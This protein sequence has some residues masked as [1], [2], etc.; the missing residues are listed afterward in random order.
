M[1]AFFR[2]GLL[3]CFFQTY[4]QVGINTT[5]PGAQLEIKASN[6][7]APANNDGIIIPKVDAFPVTN[8]TATQQ[9]M[10]VYLT[11]ASG[12]NTP[13][14][15][16]WDNAT[17]SWIGIVSTANGDKDWYKAGTTD[18]P[19]N[20]DSMYHMG[21]V[22]IGLNSPSFPLH[23]QSSL[24]DKV[25]FWGSGAN[26]YGF[27]L[28]S[29]LFQI[30][31]D[32]N[33]SDIAFGYGSSAA[34]TETVRFKGNGFVGIG[35]TNPTVPLQF[36]WGLGDRISF[37]GNAAAH[38]GIGI[39]DYLLQIHG[40]IVSDDIAFGYGSSASFTERMRIKG[41]GNVGIGTSSPSSRLHIQN[42]TSGITA[43]GSSL[44]TVEGSGANV[45]ANIL[46][47]QE[48]GVLFGASGA[49][50]NGG[51][52][53][54]STTYPNSMMF[55]TG[56]NA[57]RMI[58]GST[59]KVALGNFT[60]TVQ[61]EFDNVLGE[62]I[63]L[64]GTSSNM[65]GFGIQSALLQMY[66]PS[67]ANDIAFGYG[68]TD[69][70]VERMRI[71]GTGNVG[72]GTSAPS[73]RLHVQNG[74]SGIAANGSSLL[75]VE[76]SGTNVYTNLL[77]TQETGVLFGASGASANGGVIYNSTAYPNSMMFRTGG[78]TNRMVIGST[79]NVALGNFT[80]EFPLHFSDGYGD[81]VS[82]WGSTLTNHYGFGIQNKLLQIYAD[83]DFSDIA[84][85]Y[86]SS[87]S[88]TERMRIKGSGNIGIGTTSPSSKLHVRGN[89]SGMTPNTSALV[90]IENDVSTYMNLL[91]G[92]E[93]GVLFGSNATA[94]SGGI[95]YNSAGVPNGLLFRT[96]NNTTKMVVTSDGF[97]GV[98]GTFTPQVPLHIT[99][100]TLGEKI[101]IYG[102]AAAN[103]GFGIQGNLMQIHSDLSGSDIA[104]GYG[105]SSSFTERMRIKGTGE[106]GIGTNAPTAEL[107]VNGFTKMGGSTAPAVKMIKLTGTT[108]NTQ[109]GFVQLVHGLTSSKILSASVLV[110][111]S[112]GNSVP[113]SYTASAGYEYDYYVSSTSVVVWNKT[114]NSANILTKPIRVLVTYEE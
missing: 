70:L 61:L 57:N 38:H 48:T 39:Q 52:I 31:S 47:T 86:G 79:G 103:Y 77:S 95:I 20:T 35:N 55:R 11:T 98:G 113:P 1:K 26:H 5:T 75:T 44:L 30:H 93:T 109:G 105:S 3:F 102:S 59:G 111:Y 104:F 8:P 66:T 106:V 85:G 101:A 62:K 6:Q 15:Y 28:Q 24:G 69:A 91:S 82:L 74:S 81:K 46:S 94:T 80:P 45:Y 107:E 22:G 90:T 99:D 9:G 78:N 88:F 36:G 23:F 42:G 18:T 17:T 53:Y 14:F 96:N 27:G 10:M 25:S 19:S 54:N 84:F 32:F 76:G 110:E 83:Y 68:T 56:G 13:G 4:A 29:N 7:S 34:F 33:F 49:S 16:Y 65:Y 72:I 73:S 71:K 43:N 87:A 89:S 97:V 67:S 50:A 64:F 12:S 60:P 63:C 2:L 100:Y 114:A 40:G 51:V 108:S 41:T 37:Y 92:S 58:I 21:N 112:S